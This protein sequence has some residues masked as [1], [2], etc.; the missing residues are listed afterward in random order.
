MIFY[1]E[2][3]GDPSYSVVLLK[4]QD[5]NIING[6]Q[7]IL[8]SVTSQGYLGETSDGRWVYAIE[9]NNLEN[10]ESVMA[11]L[12][13]VQDAQT[14][15]GQRMTSTSLRI[16]VPSTCPDVTLNNNETKVASD[17]DVDKGIDLMK[18]I[19]QNITNGEAQ[20]LGYLSIK[21]PVSDD[22]F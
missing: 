17:F 11:E 14:M 13:R 20:T 5:G 16:D 8:A 3:K 9:D 10:V 4:D 15:A 19:A 21:L 6:E 2:Y 7:L 12:Y 22:G 18:E 1:G